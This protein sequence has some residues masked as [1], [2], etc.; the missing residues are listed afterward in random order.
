MSRRGNT[1]ATGRGNIINR[2]IPLRKQNEM[3][4]I[5]QMKGLAWNRRW[6]NSSTIQRQKVE[7]MDTGVGE[8]EAL[9]PRGQGN[10]IRH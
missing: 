6:S 5:D 1:E 9:M 8:P 7:R 2:S 10:P 3:G 4:S